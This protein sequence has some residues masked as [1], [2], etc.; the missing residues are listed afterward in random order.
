MLLEKLL[1]YAQR[2]DIAPELPPSGYA[3]KRVKWLITLDPEGNCQYLMNLAT[4][5]KGKGASGVEMLIPDLVRTSGIEAKLLADNA[6]YVL[7]ISEDPTKAE[8]VL[9]QHE[10]FKDMLRQCAEAT[11]HPGVRAVLRFLERLPESWNGHDPGE[12]AARDNVTFEVE[13]MGV[14]VDLP[15]IRAYWAELRRRTAE[16]DRPVQQCMVCG[17][18]RPIMSVMPVMI[19]GVP[20]TNKSGAALISANCEAFEHYDFK[21]AEHASLCYDCAERTHRA[22]NHLLAGEHNVWR[23]TNVVYTAWTDGAEFDLFGLLT[24]PDPQVVVE[25]LKAL[26]NGKTEALSAETER[27]YALA[28]SG[29]V[30]RIAIRDWLESTVDEVKRRVAR[31]FALQKLVD[32]DGGFCPSYGIY[33]LAKSTVAEGESVPELLIDD[34][35]RSVLHGMPLSETMLFRA[36][37]RTRVERML[38]RPR[39]VLIKMILTEKLGLEEEALVALDLNRPEAAYHLGRLLAVYERLQLAANDA[40]HLVSRHFG[41]AS[42][43][44]A[45]AFAALDRLA[46]VHLQKLNRHGQWDVMQALEEQIMEIKNHIP[47]MPMRLNMREQGLFSLGY[48]HQRAFDRARAREKAKEKAKTA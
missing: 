12:I 19:F 42:T 35:F 13:G 26:G 8:R 27:I 29:N 30:A 7:G 16:K 14:L 15:E 11:H 21:G 28:L 44:P 23:G 37:H 32:V 34:L 41:S 1:A 25:L 4:A 20:G 47:T 43:A 48:W 5:E 33:A 39:A 38:T 45:T 6:A 40:T 2:P 31:F 46:H 24:A 10:A 22:L 18:H 17:E 36:I 3:S 9:Q